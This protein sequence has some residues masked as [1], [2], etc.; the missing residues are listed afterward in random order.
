MTKKLRDII[1]HKLIPAARKE[2][3]SLLESFFEDQDVINHIKNVND[4]HEVHVGFEKHPLNP[5]QY[6]IS[7]DVNSRV[8]PS[9]KDRMD[10]LHHVKRTVEQFVREKKP[11]RL[12]MFSYSTKK[13]SMYRSFGLAL[14]KKFKGQFVPNDDYIHTIY[15]PHRGNRRK[16]RN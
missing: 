7:F 8:Q 2:V 1:S 3:K 15:F 6:D 11:Q 16:P 4:H 5:D 9:D 13:H 10:I 14:A 12:T